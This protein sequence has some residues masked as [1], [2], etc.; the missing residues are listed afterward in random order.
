MRGDWLVKVILFCWMDGKSVRG[1]AHKEWLADIMDWYHWY[2]TTPAVR[3]GSNL[4]YLAADCVIHLRGVT[5][6]WME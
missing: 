4:H 5:D 3:A 6:G 1:R 2:G